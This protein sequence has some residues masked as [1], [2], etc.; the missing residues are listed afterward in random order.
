MFTICSPLSLLFLIYSYAIMMN[1][2]AAD[3]YNERN[4]KYS[5]RMVKTYGATS[6]EIDP[7]TC[8]LKES[9]KLHSSLSKKEIKEMEDR[10][11]DM[12]L[13]R[14]DFLQDISYES[15]CYG[16]YMINAVY[17]VSF[18]GLN[19]VIFRYLSNKFAYYLTTVIT[20]LGTL[21]YADYKYGHVE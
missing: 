12:K 15:M 20:S 7:K 10:H 16:F 6:E 14:W 2:K 17:L 19:F 18:V 4:F 11:I 1:G 13:Q 8:K 3:L 9:S 21:S 5:E